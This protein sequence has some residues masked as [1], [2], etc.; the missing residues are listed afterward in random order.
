M[1]GPHQRNWSQQNRTSRSM[2]MRTALQTAGQIAEPDGGGEEL[3]R[4]GHRL[5]RWSWSRRAERVMA[6]GW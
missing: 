2:L 3:L 4:G 6:R 5:G 1:K